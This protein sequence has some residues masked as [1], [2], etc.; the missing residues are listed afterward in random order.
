MPIYR[1]MKSCFKYGRNWV[2]LL[3][4][5]N[6]FQSGQAH[7]LRAEL[8][9]NPASIQF[10][11]Q[12]SI[13]QGELR[14]EAVGEVIQHKAYAHLDVK[15]GIAYINAEF[16]HPDNANEDVRI[17]WRLYGWDEGSVTKDALHPGNNQVTD[18]IKVVLNPTPF[19]VPEHDFYLLECR[20][21]ILD[22]SSTF[23]QFMTTESRYSRVAPYNGIWE[24]TGEVNSDQAVLHTYL[25][26]KPAE[27]P[28]DP[29]TLR[30][31]PMAGWV[32]FL[33]YKDAS[34]QNKV[35]ESDFFPVDDYIQH[36]GIGPWLRT[37]Y[38]FRWTVTGLE[39]DTRYYYQVVTKSSDEV[40]QRT[41]ANVNT[42][43][44]VPLK[45][46]TN[47]V[48]FVVVS[49][50]DPINTAYS[51][52]ADGEQRGLKTF[53]SMLSP[54]VPDFIVMT[55]DTVYYDGYPPD[56]GDA[57]GFLKRWL[58]WYAYYQF[59]NFRN[60]F[61]VVPG[62]WMVD[63]HDYW[64]NNTSEIH[65]DGWHIFRNVNPTP[66]LYGTVGEN[67]SGYYETNPYG[68]SQG[69]GT[70]F[71]R[72]IRWGKHLELF[73]EEGHH[74]RDEN[75]NLIWGDEQRTWLEQR[76]KASGATY[77]VLVATTP[78]IGPVPP[79]DFDP[80]FIPD[81]H[82]NDKFRAE[83][84]LFLNN[85]KDVSNVFIVAG[86]RHYKYH[87]V[88]NAENFP[89]LKHFHEF[90]PGA[91]AGP[92]HAT[93]GGGIA[94]SD[95]AIRVYQDGV[96]GSEGTAG[97]LRVEVT[98]QTFGAAIKYDL[99]QV[100]EEMDNNIVHSVTFS[101]SNRQFLPVLMN[102]DLGGTQ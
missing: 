21:Q 98:D 89:Q 85:I 23:I 61:Q 86:D 73:I 40:D 95:L 55:G 6:I 14:G 63:D 35:T 38:N 1:L 36:N 37:N 8:E 28:T 16:T 100:T 2:M 45:H 70:E 26:E 22:E 101:S 48:V 49:G 4:M 68:T 60:F 33:V 9:E 46:D 25:T 76:I 97:Y 31:S 42:F 56:I 20:N 19:V 41:A 7:R 77:K 29:D 90:G 88:I 102:S 72:A 50:V 43:R 83:T 57:S 94:Q 64:E 24:R 44:T 96:D 80:T 18:F 10:E 51:D 39:P 71:W 17:R 3:V 75:A 12:S 78:L 52:P 67:A 27:D 99:I 15:S 53:A 13:T 30:V 58:F 92:P 84:E 87:G 66:G 69:D 74:H 82:V 59:D 79:D 34:L 81:K 54:Q 93:G 47:D 62:Y 91:A 5:F 11:D 32:Q 65:P